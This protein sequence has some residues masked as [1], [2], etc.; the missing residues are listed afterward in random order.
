[1]AAERQSDKMVSDME[2]QMKQRRGVEFLHMEKIVSID[3][4]QCLL[5]RCLLETKQWM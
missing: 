4:H 2:E 1:M 3:I 5:N